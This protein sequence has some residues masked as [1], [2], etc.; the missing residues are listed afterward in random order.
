MSTPITISMA[1]GVRRQVRGIISP[2]PTL[3]PWG[4]GK[5]EGD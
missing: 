2:H 5:G 1:Q 4:R 3:S